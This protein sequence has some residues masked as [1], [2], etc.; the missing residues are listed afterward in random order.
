MKWTCSFCNSINPE[1][2]P[3]CHTCYNHNYNF[4]GLDYGYNVDKLKEELERVKQ[5]LRIALDYIEI[6][7]KSRQE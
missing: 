3:H 6:L 2:A 5:E 7:T 1:L 4:S